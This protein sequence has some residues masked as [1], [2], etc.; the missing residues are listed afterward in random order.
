MSYL[1]GAILLQVWNANLLKIGE[2]RRQR[3]MVVIGFNY[4]SA[5]AIAAVLWAMEGGAAPA[6]ITWIFGAVAGF[7]YATALFFFMAAIAR[8]GLALSTAGMRLSVLWPVLLSLAAFGEVPTALQWSGIGLTLTVVAMLGRTGLRASRSA[9]GGLSGRLLLLAL[10]LCMGGGLST[11]KAF[12]E[13]D[14]PATRSAML[15]L[16][17]APAGL[18]SWAVVAGPNLGPAGDNRR[19]DGRDAL[20]GLLFGVGNVASNAFLLLGLE[21]VDGVVAFPLV[22]IGVILL[23][24]LSG[25]LLWRER[26]GRVET[27]ALAVATLAIVLMTL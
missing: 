20:M 13:M 25:V 18:I 9:Q 23:N 12:S 16:L 26:L 21:Q 8:S 3:R 4:L 15:A 2:S 19:I 27:A 1:L 11:L 14:R 24:S 6:G 17:F 10:F 22:N 7:F 5:T